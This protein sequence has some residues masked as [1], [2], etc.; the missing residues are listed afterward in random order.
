M[1]LPC[2]PARPRPAP[3]HAGPAARG[4][5]PKTAKPAWPNSLAEQVQAVRAALQSAPAPATAKEIA[6]RF[7]PARASAVAEL[8]AALAT[9]GQARPTPDGRF[10]A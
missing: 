6:A 4:P 5:K 7:K 2:A 1:R 9:L 8:L 10:A 3:L